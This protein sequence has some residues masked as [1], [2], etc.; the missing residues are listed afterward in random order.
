MATNEPARTQDEYARRSVFRNLELSQCSSAHRGLLLDKFVRDQGGKENN[1]RQH[2]IDGVCGMTYKVEL[3]SLYQAAYARWKAL[4][5][6]SESVAF[7]A[8]TAAPLAIG[9]GAK[10]V[11]D[12]GVRLHRTYGLPL[13]PGS[14]VRGALSAFVD[15]KL[16]GKHPELWSA[17]SRPGE[18]NPN[19]QGSYHR[20]LFGDTALAGRLAF[21]D[22]WWVPAAGHPLRRDVI[23]P[24]HQAYYT[25]NATQ[26]VEPAETDDPVPVTIPVVPQGSQFLFIVA[27]RSRPGDNPIEAQKWLGLVQFLLPQMLAQQGLGAKRSQGYGRMT[28]ES[29]ATSTAATAADNSG[30]SLAGPQWTNQLQS[31]KSRL[32]Q[33]LQQIDS[34]KKKL[35]ELERMGEPGVRE[36]LMVLLKEAKHWH[37]KQ[38]DKA[39]ES[40]PWMVEWVKG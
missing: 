8:T 33:L 28:A 12:G 24:H 21:E 11:I 20:L 16:G 5:T 23:T 19:A 7:E 13:I 15:E 29:A 37:S 1:A 31:Y 36:P 38:F 3:E 9:H 2:L 22:A 35:D 34:L 30:P 14:S 25:G 27:W 40:R 26:R 4:W 6:L 32:P 10:G 18:E 17:G 39:A